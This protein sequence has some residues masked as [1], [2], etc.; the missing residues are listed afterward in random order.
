MSHALLSKG[1][2]TLDGSGGAAGLGL[3]SSAPPPELQAAALPFDWALKRSLRLHSARP[4]A[5]C[6][7]MLRMDAEQGEGR[8]GKEGAMHCLPRTLWEGKG[9]L[10]CR[11][12]SIR[13]GGPGGLDG[14]RTTTVA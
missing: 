14:S 10:S 13:K 7:Q 11:L 1:S 5:V 8:G 2:G 12:P 9:R 3:G 6:E 4:F